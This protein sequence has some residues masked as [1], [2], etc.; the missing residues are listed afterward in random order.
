MTLIC[1]KFATICLRYTLIIWIS[2]FLAYWI[3]GFGVGFWVWYECG[4]LG[5]DF[6]ER[7]RERERERMGFVRYTYIYPCGLVCSEIPYSIPTTSPNQRLN[8]R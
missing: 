1:F 3:I 5:L 8:E 6:G 4:F 7:E 2:R